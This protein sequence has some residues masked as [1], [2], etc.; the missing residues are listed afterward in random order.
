MFKKNKFQ[1]QRILVHINQITIFVEYLANCAASSIFNSFPHFDEYAIEPKKHYVKKNN[2]P[3]M[4]YTSTHLR[5]VK[6]YSQIKYK[7]TNKV[8]YF[9]N[10]KKI[11][12]TMSGS[13]PTGTHTMCNALQTCPINC[14]ILIFWNKISF[15]TAIDILIPPPKNKIH[16]D[17]K[18]SPKY[19]HRLLIRCWKTDK[20]RILFTELR[21]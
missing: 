3:G 15:K 7:C 9:V 2:C 19:L 21:C 8:K 1:F 5:Y 10:L 6:L 4:T 20:V 18:L 17:H 11:T 16:I 12:S 13:L 14:R